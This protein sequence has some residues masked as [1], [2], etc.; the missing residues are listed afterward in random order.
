MS[1]PNPQC[2][3]RSSCADR[4]AGRSSPSGIAAYGR[5]CLA[6]SAYKA[7]LGSCREHQ[8]C[9]GMHA[10]RVQLRGQGSNAGGRVPRSR[11]SA[12][13]AVERR[14]RCSR[15]PSS[16]CRCPLSP[17]QQFCSAAASGGHWPC[18]CTVRWPM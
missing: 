12:V 1:V 5:L 6:A 9:R 10:C 16:R 2:C 7:C 17:Q 4:H 15:E 13:V 8:P 18:P 11:R 14:G 3:S